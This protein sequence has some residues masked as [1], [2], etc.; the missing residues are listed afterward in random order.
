MRLY[1]L[2]TNKWNY[3]DEIIK[4]DSSKGVKSTF[5]IGVNNGLGLNYS[6]NKSAFWINEIIKNDFNIGVH[7]IEYSIL[8]EMKKEFRLFMDI[9]KLNSFGVRMH[10]LR[11]D[12][13]TINLLHKTGYKYDSTEYKL[14]NPY[15]VGGIW[16]FPLH[17]MDGYEIQNS[18]GWQVKKIEQI[19]DD[20]KMRIAKIQKLGLRYLTL[21]FHDRYY[22][23]CHNTWKIWYE[24]FI[25]WCIK[26]KLQFIDYNEAI[27][28]LEK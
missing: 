2:F 15:K 27:V 17:I 4:F 3:I 21:L 9:S 10:Y 23:D 18:K 22:S 5:F 8:E 12:E 16:E 14:A 13:N 26:N 25:D 20:T 19:K 7:G 1:E 28:E 11:K 6:L 24:W